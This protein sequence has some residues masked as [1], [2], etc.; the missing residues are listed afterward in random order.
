MMVRHDATDADSVPEREDR[1][2]DA[3]FTTGDEWTLRA[4][5]ARYGALVYRVA[6]NLLTN[7][8]DAEEVTQEV[9]VSAWQGRSTY[10]PAAGTLGAWLVGITRRR[11]IDRF[12]LLER[13][14]RARTA[15][16]AEPVAEITDG[17]ADRVID[18]IVVADELRRLP[19]SQRR[20]LELAFFDDLTHGQIAAL[21]GLPLGTVK[22]HLR[23]GMDR[24]RTRREVDGANA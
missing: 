16:R 22:S 1:L 7:P 6:R 3:A 2:L 17:D 8:A 12:R 4:A 9:F 15:S 21:T 18:R 20:L 11:V 24:L 5:Y 10:D 13:E 23:R 14:Q 19:Q